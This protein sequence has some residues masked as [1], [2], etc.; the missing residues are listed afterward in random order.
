MIL[1]SNMSNSV[2]EYDNNIN[3]YSSLI[4]FTFV[5][6]FGS[7]LYIY[8]YFNSQLQLTNKIFNNKINRNYELLIHDLN[9]Y[10]SKLEQNKEDLLVYVNENIKS[11]NKNY[12]IQSIKDLQLTN[13]E[14]HQKIQNNL[15]IMLQN[16]N[17][18]KTL[19]DERIDY[20]I[21]KENNLV[22]I[23]TFN[24]NCEKG[25]LFVERLINNKMFEDYLN[26]LNIHNEKYD[27]C[28]YPSQLHKLTNITQINIPSNIY[29]RG[30]SFNINNTN[31]ICKILNSDHNPTLIYVKQELQKLKEYDP[32]FNIK[33][34]YN[35]EVL[36][37]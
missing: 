30:V 27:F 23:G 14:L 20:V 6:L 25:C 10:S 4:L 22:C 3:I 1:T 15:N 29:R 28:I 32:T 17:T 5:S 11:I 33:I 37:E 26:E 31:I 12:L 7:I 24:G 19:L 34:L 2:C 9:I 36:F 35:N 18:N 16:L 13:K 21:R 8:N